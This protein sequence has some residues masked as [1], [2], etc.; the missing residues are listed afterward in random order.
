MGLFYLGDGILAG[1]DI[2]GMKYDGT[3]ELQ[4]VDQI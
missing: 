3:Y 4:L 2:S 1:V